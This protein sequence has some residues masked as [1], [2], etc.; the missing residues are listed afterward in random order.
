LKGED[1]RQA[2]VGKDNAMVSYPLL[3]DESGKSCA[4][5]SKWLAG[6]SFVGQDRAGRIVIGTT[7][8]AFLS[9]D[10]FANLLHAAPLGLALALSL[11]GG[12]VACQAIDLG[13][14]NAKPADRR[15]CRSTTARCGCFSP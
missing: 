2:F 11:D 12:P 5:P 1:W 4:S 13:S 15:N 10:R 8:D 14:T 7:A 3:V 9:L 6:R